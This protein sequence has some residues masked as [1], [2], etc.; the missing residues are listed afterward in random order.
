M[1]EGGWGLLTISGLYREAWRGGIL[2]LLIEKRVEKIYCLR[3][4]LLA[5]LRELF[6]I[7]LRNAKNP[8]QAERNSGKDYQ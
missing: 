2:A 1:G 5:C 8:L 7:V 4:L 3:E 6:L